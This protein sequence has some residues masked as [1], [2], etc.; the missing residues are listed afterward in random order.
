MR[1][2]PQARKLEGADKYK[3]VGTLTDKFDKVV[4]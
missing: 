4:T 3:L 2:I 1:A